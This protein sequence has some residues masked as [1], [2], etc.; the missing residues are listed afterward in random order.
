M[1]ITSD[2]VDKEEARRIEPLLD[3]G[4]FSSVVYEP[5]MGYAEPSTTAGSFA[6]AAV[7]LGGQSSDGDRPAHISAGLATDTHSRR[8]PA[9]WRLARSCSPRESGPALSSSPWGLRCRSSLL[10]TPSRSSAVPRSSRGL[11]PAVFDFIRSAYCKAEGR[12]LLFVGFDGGRARR[13][14]RRR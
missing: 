2:F 14:E 6:A 9:R 4:D 7:T 1:G 3:T 13:I 11:R 8:P 5:H 12:D 10:G